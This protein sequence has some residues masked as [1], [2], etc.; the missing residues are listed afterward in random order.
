VT[1]KLHHLALAVLAL[2][3][4]GALGAGAVEP[5]EI[6]GDPALEAR[7]RDIDRQLRCVVCQSQSIAESDAPLA[8]DLRLLVRERLVAGDS[9]EEVRAFVSERYGD[10]V[11]LSPSLQ[12]STIFLWAFPALIFLLACAAAVLYLRRA[13]KPRT[14]ASSAAAAATNDEEAALQKLIDERG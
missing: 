6:L 14:S 8:K 7:A 12:P 3:C 1:A 4:L 5:D 11:L 9:D 10:Y 13:A 2:I